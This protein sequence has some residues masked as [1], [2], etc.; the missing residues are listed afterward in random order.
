MA[1]ITLKFFNYWFFIGL[2]LDFLGEKVLLKMFIFFYCLW[3]SLVG[4]FLS[5]GYYFFSSEQT[6]LINRQ[7]RRNC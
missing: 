2:F 1:G 4:L 6:Q 3:E 5:T 7:F